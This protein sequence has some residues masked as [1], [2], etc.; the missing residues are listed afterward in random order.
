MYWSF[1]KK[2]DCF[3]EYITD[4]QAEFIHK[5]SHLSREQG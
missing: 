3:V 2:I 1:A 4:L 5:L